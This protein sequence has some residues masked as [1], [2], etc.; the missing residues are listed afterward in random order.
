MYFSD[1]R[2]YGRLQNYCNRIIKFQ[3]VKPEKFYGFVLKSFIKWLSSIGIHVLCGF[4]F[5]YSY[6]HVA[7]IFKSTILLVEIN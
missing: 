2:T 3:I 6:F 7:I 5:H 4:H 1:Y